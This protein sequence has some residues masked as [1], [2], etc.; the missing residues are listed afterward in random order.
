MII[1]LFNEEAMIEPLTVELS[2][3]FSPEA[4]SKHGVSRIR[5]VMIDD[6]SSDRTAAALSALISKG[7]PAVLYRLSRNFGHQNALCAGLDRTD[8]DAT[9]DWCEQTFAP[10]LDGLPLLFNAAH[11]TFRDADGLMRALAVFVDGK[12]DFADYVIQ[13]HA[14][15]AGCAGVATFDRTLLKETGFVAP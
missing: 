13:E 10:W 8:A 15:A 3:V 2:R 5:Y 7:F 11:L 14:R 12:G 9:V 6:G 4:L 1:P